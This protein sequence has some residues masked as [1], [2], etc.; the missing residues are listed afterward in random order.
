MK[1][2]I[3]I[4]VAALAACVL[5]PQG[6][7]LCVG[8]EGHVEFEL[9]GAPCCDDEPGDAGECEDC[10]DTGRPDASTSAPPRGLDAPAPADGEATLAGTAPSASRVTEAPIPLGVPP[11]LLRSVVLVV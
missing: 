1:C 8:A 4:L 2:R 11:E 10:A 3:L 7:L 9:E 6:V 5:W